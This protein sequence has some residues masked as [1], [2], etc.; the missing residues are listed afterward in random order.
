MPFGKYDDLKCWNPECE[1][2]FTPKTPWQ[3]HCT[4]DCRSR[5]T[6]LRTTLPKRIRRYELKLAA[7]E[8]DPAKSARAAVL[9]ARLASDKT[10]VNGFRMAMKGK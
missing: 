9:R 4:E 6:Y 7:M 10:Q 2:K 8:A 3:R 5:C 1:K